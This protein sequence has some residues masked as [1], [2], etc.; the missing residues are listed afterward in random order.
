ML[1]S[2]IYDDFL[3]NFSEW[4][5]W[6]DTLKF[7]PVVNEV[8]GVTYPGICTA[9]PTFGM[10]KLLAAVM[11][12]EVQLNAL[13][14]RLSLAGVSVPHQ[15]HHDAVMG[16]FSLMLYMNRAE[17]CRGGTSLIEHVDGEPDVATWERD[18]NVP[19]KWRVI[20]LAQMRPNR[21]FI[22]RSNL[23]HRA[24]PL[25]GFG[26]DATDGRLVLTAFYS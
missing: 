26:A 2:V 1:H 21:A 17:H 12:R 8:D 16:D 15:A 4:R 5:S 25:G 11:G 18:T 7:P 22:F 9:V 13:F 14:L 10:R 6:A 24:E 3:P 23:W 19:E 20:S